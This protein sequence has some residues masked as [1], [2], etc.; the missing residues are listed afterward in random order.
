MSTLDVTQHHKTR[1]SVVTQEDKTG[2]V[3]ASHIM[4]SEKGPAAWQ[5]TN[6]H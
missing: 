2:C 1:M 4:Y 5:R 6:T 3:D